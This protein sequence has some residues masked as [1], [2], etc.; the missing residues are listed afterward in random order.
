MHLVAPPSSVDAAL[1]ALV[2]SKKVPAANCYI[3]LDVT[4]V[5]AS[6]PVYKKLLRTAHSRKQSA[7]CVPLLFG[8]SAY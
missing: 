1:S 3:N 6:A 7:S 2:G 4:S 5:M 8:M